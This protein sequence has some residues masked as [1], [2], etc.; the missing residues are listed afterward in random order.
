[1]KKCRKHDIKK[2]GWHGE[3]E[4]R[5]KLAGELEIMAYLYNKIM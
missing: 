5:K 4:N 3:K 2:A 1:V